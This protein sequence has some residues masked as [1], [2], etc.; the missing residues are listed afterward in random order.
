MFRSDYD[1]IPQYNEF[2]DGVLDYNGSD[3]CAAIYSVA[4]LSYYV[5]KNIIYNWY[6]FKIY[7][8]FGKKISDVVQKNVGLFL[9]WVFLGYIKLEVYYFNLYSH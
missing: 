4:A 1:K 8:N 9:I 5:S 6:I 2:M 7:Q 3:D